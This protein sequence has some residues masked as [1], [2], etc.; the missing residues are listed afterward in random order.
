MKQVALI[1]MFGFEEFSHDIGLFFR[2]FAYNK[3]K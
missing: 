2:F 3:L 1:V